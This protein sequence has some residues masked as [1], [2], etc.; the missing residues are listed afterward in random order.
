MVVDVLLIDD[1]RHF[2]DS[3]AEGLRV[4]HPYKLSVVTTDSG[5]KAI[6]MLKTVTFDVVV[7]DL[8][9]PGVDGYQLLTHMRDKH[10]GI[11]VIIMSAF[12]KAE[13]EK[14]LL[15]LRFAKYIEKPLALDEVALAI[16]SAA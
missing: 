9:M 1:E 8:H 7:T 15:H 6:E 16:L 5:E 10:P 3:L 12:A 11:P 4:L 14:Q 2:L 13:V